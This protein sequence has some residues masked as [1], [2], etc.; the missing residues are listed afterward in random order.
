MQ[1]LEKLAELIK[2]KGWIAIR[3]KRNPKLLQGATG[4]EEDNGGQITVLKG[5]PFN[6]VITD[7]KSCCSGHDEL[8]VRL[9]GPGQLSTI[10]HVDS[11]EQAMYWL[12]LFVPVME[13]EMNDRGRKT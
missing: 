11:T 5:V 6:V 13:K 4:P 1:R 8:E 10:T 12:E 2:S 3:S 9:G 7:Q